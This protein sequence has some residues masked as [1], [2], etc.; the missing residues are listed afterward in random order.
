MLSTQSRHCDRHTNVHYGA[1]AN[2]LDLDPEWGAIDLL[3]EVEATFG[4]A[5][6]D[7]EA[8]RC[9]TLGDL[10]DILCA[11]LP[12]WDD[13][14][15]RCGSSMVFYR[16]R[17][18]LSPH[19]KRG[20]TPQTLLSDSGLQP[21]RLFKKLAEDTGLRLPDH[22]L[23]WRGVTG[24]FLL[25]GGTLG[26]VVALLEGHWLVGGIA[27]LTSLS[28]LPLARTDPG[29]FPVGMLTIGDLVRRTVP[30]NV[31]ILTDAGGRPPD[32]W[33]ILVALAAEHGTLSPSEIGPETFFHRRSLEL[34]TAR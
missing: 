5:I 1:M 13:Q 26:A 22:E 32:R 23:T 33:S 34:A 28:G 10:N 30:L 11:H 12:D 4:I 15:G 31:A 3:E 21:S 9:C 16:L 7:E 6:A 27:V 19:N 24:G 17:R 14:D 8:E 2:S 29:R 18:S 25:A 20:V